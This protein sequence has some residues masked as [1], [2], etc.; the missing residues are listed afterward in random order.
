M[1][2]PEEQ[3]PGFERLEI[4]VRNTLHAFLIK[5]MLG[6]DAHNHEKQQA[7]VAQYG[8]RVSDLID[9]PGHEDI[10]DLARAGNYAEA[11]ERLKA[12]L[13]EGDK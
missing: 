13:I 6:A 10:R 3:N 7:W 2:T 11:V 4:S 8:K 1:H 5:D 12:L 9:F